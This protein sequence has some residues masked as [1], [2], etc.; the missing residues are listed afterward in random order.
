MTADFFQPAN[1]L[2]TLLG[3]GGLAAAA[4]IQFFL[5]HRCQQVWLRRAPLLGLAA[6]AVVLAVMTVVLFPQNPWQ[7]L[8]L[9]LGFFYV[10]LLMAFC[11]LGW[12]IAYVLRPKHPRS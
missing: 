9:L 12:L 7:A 6:A 1:L 8:S 10:L 3:L 2:T 11:A 5:S 4:V